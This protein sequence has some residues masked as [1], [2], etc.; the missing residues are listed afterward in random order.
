[1]T[2]DPAT[3]TE[4]PLI[5][6]YTDDVHPWFSRDG[7]RLLYVRVTP[8]GHA[9]FWV[10]NA[11]GSDAHEVVPKPVE[12]AEWS[13]DSATLVAT[14]LLG[15][16]TETG[17]YN[18]L[19]GTSTVLDVGVEIE[20]PFWRPGHDQLVFSTTTVNADRAYY[21]VNVDGSGLRRIEGVATGAID[22]PSLSPDGSK[23]AYATWG[24]GVGAGEDIHVLE[25]ETGKDIIATPVDE[26]SYQDVLFS[27]D[28]STILTKRFVPSG[29]IQLAIVPADGQ[30]DVIPIGPSLAMD[31]D[32][33]GR[34][35]LWQFSPDGRQVLAYFG[36]NDSTWLLDVDGSGEQQVAWSGRYGATWQ[37][38]AP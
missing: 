5:G 13:N 30:G 6:P 23:L 2:V 8:P 38:L 16:P 34:G 19:D 26:Y 15:G 36:K 14:R 31:M 37:R 25:I 33:Q 32:D 35:D 1:V 27:P 21:L 7:R 3:G 11:D 20:H 24:S 9:A 12:W 18:V 28:G 22:D 29:P 4:M 10:A 17:I